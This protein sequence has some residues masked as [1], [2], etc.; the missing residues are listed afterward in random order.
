MKKTFLLMLMIASC[1]SVA[2]AQLM[3]D[4]TGKTGIGIETNATSDTLKS[5]FVINDEG[6][7]DAVSFIKA[8]NEDAYGLYIKNPTYIGNTGNYTGLYVYAN[9]LLKKGYVYGVRSDIA[10]GG[11]SSMGTIGVYGASGYSKNKRNYGVVGILNQTTSTDND[12]YGA[13]VFG[14]STNKT[15]LQLDGRYAG[16]F[17]GDTRVTG[18]LTAG[19]VVTSSDY[20]LKENIRSLSSSDGCLGKLMDMNVVEFSNKQREYE[21]S[22]ME[23]EE[24]AE[25]ELLESDATEPATAALNKENADSKICWY[26]EDSPIIKNKHYGLIAQE[27]QKE[28]DE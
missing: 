9:A 2:N 26:E 24:D 11:S 7:N 10:S 25:A 17:N 8:R 23:M 22:T 14:N 16:Y 15:L 19:S 20:R 28:L 4:A 6:R 12:S 3:V 1:F 21:A 27:L 13:A 5:M 18:V